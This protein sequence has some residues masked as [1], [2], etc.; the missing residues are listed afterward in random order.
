MTKL[1][2]LISSLL[3]SVNASIESF[4]SVSGNL[5]CPNRTNFTATIRLMESDSSVNDFGAQY[6]KRANKITAS[7][8]SVSFVSAA[9]LHDGWLDYDLEPFIQIIHD[10][11]DEDEREKDVEEK[12]SFCIG[13]PIVTTTEEYF[14]LGDLDLSLTTAD[15]P[16]G[17]HQKNCHDYGTMVYA[18]RGNRLVLLGGIN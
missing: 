11:I 10:C 8:S 13:L 14:P 15:L 9:V 5:V 1:L 7:H 3:L 12:L 16:F 18:Q 17:S 4:I 2:S 6:V